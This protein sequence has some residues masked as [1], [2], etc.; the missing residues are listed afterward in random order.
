MRPK[1]RLYNVSFCHYLNNY[2]F[3]NNPM[4]SI[5]AVAVIILMMLICLFYIAPFSHSRSLYRFMSTH[6]ARKHNKKFNITNKNKKLIIHTEGLCSGGREV[7]LEQK[8]LEISFKER[9]GP[10]SVLSIPLMF[11][12]LS[13]CWKRAATLIPPQHTGGQRLRSHMITVCT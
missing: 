2:P 6:R 1:T 8:V 5:L 10:T 7:F 11:V 9:E 12:F 13:L 3:L 4:T